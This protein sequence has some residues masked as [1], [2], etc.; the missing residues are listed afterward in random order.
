MTSNL[1]YPKQSP[2]LSMQSMGG[3]AAGYMI[4]VGG[5][6]GSGEKS[7]LFDED[8]LK[9]DDSDLNIGTGAFTIEF[10][11]RFTSDA[12]SNSALPTIFECRSGGGSTSDGFMLG[13]W[14]QYNGAHEHKVSV[15]MNGWLIEESGTTAINTWNHWAVVRN[16]T[17]LTIYKDGTSVASGT[18]YSNN[19]TNTTWFLG[20][21]QNVS[22][23]SNPSNNMK[24]Y[25]SNFRFTKASV[26]TS[27]FTAPT[28]PLSVLGST[29]LLCCNQDSTSD[30]VTDSEGNAGVSLTTSQGTTGSTPTVDNTSPF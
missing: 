4:S 23:S 2:M 3:G 29:E 20:V 11:A 27:N 22:G 15:Y 25:I 24:G 18:G 9:A 12:N 7:V 5:G 6:G 30:P 21:L 14:N 1:S 16:G 28:S 26:Y 13:R 10:W 19:W 8:W 17:T